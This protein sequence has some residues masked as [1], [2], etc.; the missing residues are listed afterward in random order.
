MGPLVKD[1]AVVERAKHSDGDADMKALMALCLRHLPPDVVLR[2]F[3]PPQV[4]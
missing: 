2:L 4:H 1:A 3:A